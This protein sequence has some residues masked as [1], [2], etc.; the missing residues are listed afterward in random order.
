M[1]EM[2]Q[3]ICL[4]AMYL[5]SDISLNVLILLVSKSPFS[6][7]VK[8]SPPGKGFSTYNSV[9]DLRFHQ[10]NRRDLTPT[11]NNIPRSASFSGG[12]TA[13]LQ[14]CPTNTL[15]RSANK[16]LTATHD[17]SSTST[18]DDAYLPASDTP[19]TSRGVGGQ[20]NS[21]PHHVPRNSDS[22]PSRNR[23]TK[24]GAKISH[25]SIGQQQQATTPVLDMV[26]HVGPPLYQEHL[27]YEGLTSVKQ[28]ALGEDCSPVSASDSS[29]ESDS[30]A[31]YIKS[32]L[33]EGT[34][35]IQLTMMVY[36][37]FSSPS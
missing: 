14:E 32:S 26:S 2:V 21:R 1:C 20:V 11:S 15:R 23:S 29:P 13:R 28:G 6:S 12:P 7:P 34:G 10:S 9:S 24:L 35:S 4:F 16:D 30:C 36:H 31:P 37:Y 17:D 22:Q 8:S 33:H 18:D 27:E 25:Q 3:I 5:H 19:F